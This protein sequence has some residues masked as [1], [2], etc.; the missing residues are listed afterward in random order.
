MNYLIFLKKFC[1]IE[2]DNVITNICFQRGV[3]LHDTLLCRLDNE[4]LM[5]MTMVDHTVWT[6]YPW[7]NQTVQIIHSLGSRQ[8]ND[9]ERNQD[10]IRHL[11]SSWFGFRVKQLLPE[12]SDQL[13]QL[14]LMERL[15]KFQPVIQLFHDHISDFLQLKPTVQD[16][17]LSKVVEILQRCSKDHPIY[18]L[19]EQLILLYLDHISVVK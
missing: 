3:S 4:L 2:D 14:S 9:H 16:S 10:V 11:A 12:T 18:T 8:V 19:C 6:R 17:F 7:I 5:I 15:N 1:H 13:N